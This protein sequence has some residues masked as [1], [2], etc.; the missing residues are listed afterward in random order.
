MSFN[1]HLTGTIATPNS[2]ILTPLEIVNAWF[3]GDVVVCTGTLVQ[4]LEMSEMGKFYNFEEKLDYLIKNSE[5]DDELL[6]SLLATRKSLA[7][8]RKIKYKG[9]D[10]IIALEKVKKS[11]NAMYAEKVEKDIAQFEQY[12][13]L[14][15]I[16]LINQMRNIGF[17]PSRFRF[18]EEKSQSYYP[19]S[20]AFL[21]TIDDFRWKPL[22]TFPLRSSIV[23]Y[24]PDIQDKWKNEFCPEYE[25]VKP[26]FLY[27]L[28]NIMALEVSELKVLKLRYDADMEPIR[29]AIVQISQKATVD[30]CPPQDLLT[31]MEENLQETLTG[32]REK[33]LNDPLCRML[34]NADSN[35]YYTD[36]YVSLVPH[37]FNWVLEKLHHSLPEETLEVMEA[38][39]AKE[40]EPKPWVPYILLVPKQGNGPWKNAL[41][42][43]EWRPF[44]KDKDLPDEESPG[45]ARKVLDI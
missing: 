9:R 38:E 8:S 15:V 7:I 27:R 11:I 17:F 36:L 42:E 24:H 25:P 23:V 43:P 35:P 39:R 28:P 21:N 45:M 30:N 33:I 16:D 5:D 12:G 29:E 22:S 14:K 34:Q 37:H 18:Y 10:M 19:Y 41:T 4:L 32:I 13:Y 6:P 20:Q 3:L 1:I 40:T 31:E 2:H 44:V 26:V